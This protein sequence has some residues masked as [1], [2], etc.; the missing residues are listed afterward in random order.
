LRSSAVEGFRKSLGGE[1]IAPQ[2]AGYEEAR[3]LWNGNIDR[4]P[5][6]ICRPIGAADMMNAVRFAGEHGL[7]T[8]VR[9]GGHSFPGTSLCEGGLV[10]DLSAMLAEAGFIDIGAHKTFGGWSIVAGRKP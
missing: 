1:L 3:Q 8:A 2:D 6:L 9:G 4:R 7:L 10:I 5:G